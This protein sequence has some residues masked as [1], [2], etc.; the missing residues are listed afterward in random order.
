MADPKMEF[1]EAQFQSN[2]ERRADALA[3][4]EIQ[5]ALNSTSPKER[6]V[7]GDGLIALEKL[8]A[9]RYGLDTLETS[10]LLEEFWG[11]RDMQS[12]NY[13]G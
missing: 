13:Y 4:G 12:R 6:V 8:A 5:A 3:D 7:S 10:R 2:D 9:E 1:W 11:I